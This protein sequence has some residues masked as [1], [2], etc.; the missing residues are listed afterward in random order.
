MGDKNTT[1]S[2]FTFSYRVLHRL[3]HQNVLT[4]DSSTGT[5]TCWRTASKT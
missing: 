3:Q 2:N 4:D 5:I 1:L